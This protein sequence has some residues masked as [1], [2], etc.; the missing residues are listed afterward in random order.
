MKL[1]ELLKN[2]KLRN[3]DITFKDLYGNT[4]KKVDLTP[5]KILKIEELEVRNVDI[6]F[7]RKEATFY[8]IGLYE[9]MKEVK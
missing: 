7:I 2:Y 3:Y 9:L 5:E 1:K 6:F 8:L 4:H